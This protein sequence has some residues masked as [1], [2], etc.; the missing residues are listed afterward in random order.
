MKSEATK[1]FS[2][3]AWGLLFALVCLT[4]AA[5]LIPMWTLCWGGPAPAAPPAPASAEPLENGLVWKSGTSTDFPEVGGRVCYFDFEGA[6]VSTIQFD[7]LEI[8]K[9]QVRTLSTVTVSAQPEKELSKVDGT[10][11]AI[12]Q[13]GKVFGAPGKWTASVECDFQGEPRVSM[14]RYSTSTWVSEKLDHEV[15][16]TG[17]HASAYK[18]PKRIPV[19]IFS[20]GFVSSP[21]PKK[22]TCPADVEGCKR[23]SGEEGTT[24]LVLTA[25]W[26]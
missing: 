5:T 7:L 8:A 22:I 23:A 4:F 3:R 16:H 25:R 13:N 18:L 10:V 21:Q 11:S 19:I 12:V 2:R 24:I 26:E 9:G 15:W 17:A 1:G 6:N 14:A 20:Q